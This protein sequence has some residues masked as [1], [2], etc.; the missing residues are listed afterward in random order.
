[1]NTK[2]RMATQSPQHFMMLLIDGTP[3]PSFPS[4][5]ASAKPASMKGKYCIPLYWE[6]CRSY[7]SDQWIYVF[8]LK[9]W[10]NNANFLLEI[11]YHLLRALL[12]SGDPVSQAHTFFDQFDGA[13]LNR[14]YPNFAFLSEAYDKL[15]LANLEGSRLLTGHSHN[16]GDAAVTA[17]RRSYEQT[18][19]LCL[20]DVFRS[21]L[22]AS[23][24]KKPTIVLVH[25]VHDWTGRANAMK[26]PHLQHLGDPHQWKVARAASGNPG[27]MYKDFYTK[28][29]DWYGADGVAN[30][31]AVELF[32]P[33]TYPP[34]SPKVVPRY[35]NP[36]SD[37]VVAA[38]KDAI[39]QLAPMYPDDAKKLKLILEYGGDDSALGLDFK[40]T[41]ESGLVGFPGTVKTS[42]GER[43]N[44]RVLSGLP[45]VLWSRDSASVPKVA[46][47]VL[48]LPVTRVSDTKAEKKARKVKSR[49][50]RPEAVAPWTCACGKVY[51]RGVNSRH[52]ETHKLSC[53]AVAGESLPSVARAHCS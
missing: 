30:G 48:P 44:I 46:I 9:W 49:A 13:G 33:G 16:A 11:K 40:K 17:P 35:S 20:G 50:E 3:G 42:D 47:P 18:S 43:I 19:C 24:G 23:S 6:M 25:Q 21:L 36:F 45:E 31:R 32:K 4:W 8:S 41:F 51:A 37:S 26:N 10:P 5:A 52:A 22:A 27:L 28:G 29:N 15:G 12:S 34:P 2:S 1:M 38:T 14:S 39:K 53:V 7:S